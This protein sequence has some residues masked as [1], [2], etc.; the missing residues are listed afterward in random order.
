LKPESQAKAV[1]VLQKIRE[2]TYAHSHSERGFVLLGHAHRALNQNDAAR[3]AYRRA[4]EINPS[5]EDA[6]NALATVATEEHRSKRTARGFKAVK[7]FLIK[8]GLFLSLLIVSAVGWDRRESFFPSD[9]DVARLDPESANLSFPAVQIRYKGKIAKVTVKLGELKKMP[10]RVLDSKCRQSLDKLDMYGTKQ[11][12]LLDEQ[13]GL[14]AICSY[15]K[16][17]VF[18]KN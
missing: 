9:P 2:L 17:E 14:H 4:L 1:S 16:T 6:A 15:G 11:I 12:F 13:T 10:E 5:A 7:P 18:N 8:G 3:D